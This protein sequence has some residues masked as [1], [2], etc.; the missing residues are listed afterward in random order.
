MVRIARLA[1]LLLLLLVSPALLFATGEAEEAT[2]DGRPVI[3]AFLMNPRGHTYPE[4]TMT[5]LYLEERYDIDL[6]PFYDVDVYEQETVQVKLAAGDVP[7]ILGGFNA[8]WIDM[9]VVRELPKEMIWDNMPYYMEQ[10][11]NYIGEDQLWSRTE[12]DG[13]NY[14]VPTALSMASTGQVMGIRSDWVEAVGGDLEP[15]EGRDFY[16]GPDTLEELE[17]LF[18]KFV[19][20]DP[21]GNGEDD[22]YAYMVWQNTTGPVPRTFLPNVFGSFGVRLNTWQVE[23]GQVSYSMVDPA[24]KDALVYVQGWYEKGLIHPDTPTS[25]RADF[26]QKFANDEFAAW[27]ELDSWQSSYDNVSAPWGAL[28]AKDPDVKPVYVITPVGPTGDRGTWFRSPNWGPWSIGA[29]A[30]D[31]TAALILRMYEDIYSNRD[32]YARATFGIEGEHFEFTET[33]YARPFPEAE[34]GSAQAELGLRMLTRWVSHIVPPVAK[35][36]IAPNRYQLQSWLEENQVRYPDDG[37]SPAFSE[38]QRA[39]MTNIETIQQE[40]FWNAVTNRVNIE[41]EWD[42]YVESMNNAGLTE[43]LDAANEQFGD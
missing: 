39:M 27:S 3:T 6:Q 31:E 8:D 37:V 28:R 9:G 26:L 32:V 24:Y 23:D 2:A 21:D 41:D 22:T 18:T 1:A 36:Y 29:T 20:E 11:V 12:Y 7:H 10:A 17:E 13:V 19:E 38:S 16:R 33:G 34:E 35:T 14:A 43:L 15:V 30:D 4:D 25:V 5:E 42:S 40:F